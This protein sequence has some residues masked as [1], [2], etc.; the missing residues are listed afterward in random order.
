MM[1]GEL[2]VYVWLCWFSEDYN[3]GFW[4][5]YELSNGGFYFVF[6]L[7][8]WLCLEVDG[9]GYSGELLV[10]VVGIVVILFILG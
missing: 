2:L 1:C 5:Y 3:G 8:G 4:N 9:N 6:E 7:I 10:D